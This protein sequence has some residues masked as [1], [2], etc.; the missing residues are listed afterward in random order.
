QPVPI[1]GQDG[2]QAELMALAARHS[3]RL[4]RPVRLDEAR[5]LQQ[6]AA[7]AEGGV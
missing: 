3:L 1:N 6:L 7:A 4:G 2:Y 5:Q